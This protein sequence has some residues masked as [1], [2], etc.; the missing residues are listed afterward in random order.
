MNEFE[1]F[2]KEYCAL[3]GKC[4]RLSNKANDKVFNVEAYDINDNTNIYIR[5][6]NLNNKEDKQTTVQDKN[7][8]IV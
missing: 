7:G 2:K 6:R 4:L 1:G 8:S 5:F 3:D